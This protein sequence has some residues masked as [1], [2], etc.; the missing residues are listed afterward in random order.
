M[1]N[2]IIIFFVVL[3][4]GAWIW[5]GVKQLTKNIRKQNKELD[6]AELAI[7]DSN[8]EK[9]MTDLDKAENKIRKAYILGFVYATLFLVFSFVKK[10]IQPDLIVTIGA[11][12]LYGLS[13]GIYKR[14][15]TCSI[16]MF[17]YDS[18]GFFLVMSAGVMK[19]LIFVIVI[20]SIKTAML[21]IFFEG[22]R[23][24]LTYHKLK[25]QNKGEQNG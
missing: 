1:V 20:V 14:Y 6:L 17:I 24:T 23:G 25:N 18:F 21:Y 19:G 15:R 3:F 12:L 11:V 10:P 13:F 8:H 16:I 9:E 5:W 7:P 4:V 22:I 2:Y